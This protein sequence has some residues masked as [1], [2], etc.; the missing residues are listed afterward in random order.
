MGQKDGFL[1]YQRQDNE[2]IEPKQRIKNFH[3]FHHPLDSQQRRIQGARCMNCGVPFCQAAI[4][5][6]GKIT[7]CPLHNLV[8]E[9]NDEIY[10]GHDAH[11]LSRLLKTN[12]FPE[13]TGRV[14]PALCEKACICGLHDEPVTIKDNE[15]FIIEKAFQEQMMKPIKPT[16][17]TDKKVAVVGSGPAGLC[18]AYKLNQRGHQVTVYEKEDRVGGLLMYGIPSMKLEKSIIMRRVKMMEEEGV[19][20]KTNV[21]VGRDITKE[22]LLQQYDAVVL[23]CGSQKARDLKVK[24]RQSQGIY[25]AVD[26][27]KAVTKNELDQKIC[28]SAQGKNVVIVGGGDTGNDCVATCIRQGCTSVTQIEMMSA[29]PTVNQN[30]WPQWPNVL[31]VDYGQE[32]SLEVFHQDPRVYNA[33]ITECLHDNGKLVGVKTSKGSFVNGKWQEKPA[34]EKYLKADLLL[35]A[36]GFEGVLDGIQEAFDLELTSHHTVKT[37][38]HHYQIK[39]S[40]IFTAGD[41]HRGQ[42]LVVWAIQ[43][44]LECAKEVDYYLMGYSYMNE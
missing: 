35:I 28:P 25:F 12:P 18:V 41:M 3:E 15:L 16:V 6:E 29:P 31:K 5:I 7:G 34:S 24:G 14:C 13:L 10:H 4:E 33:I 39:N 9:W 1:R 8:P 32:E 26:F 2:V 40:Q 30:P 21:E 19:V 44:G 17:L 43:E 23:C 20:F 11:A 22:Q 27:L 36:A 37:L 42:S 38:P